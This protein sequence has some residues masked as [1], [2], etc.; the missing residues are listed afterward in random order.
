M[1]CDLHNLVKKIS[2]WG[3]NHF[4]WKQSLQQKALQ[5]GALL[6]ALE[7]KLPSSSIQSLA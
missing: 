6:V 5:V 2:K 1:S 3:L 4:G 7:Q